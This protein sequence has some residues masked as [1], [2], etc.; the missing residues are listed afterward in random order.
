[1]LILKKLFILF[2][3]YD[4]L[5]QGLLNFGKSIREFK[6]TNK[7]PVLPDA[8]AYPVFFD[9]HLVH[10]SRRIKALINDP[11]ANIRAFYFQ[12]LMLC[13]EIENPNYEFYIAKLQ[14]FIMDPNFLFLFLEEDD[15]TIFNDRQFKRFLL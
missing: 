6:N 10:P 1:V 14:K 2:K 12:Y 5:M 11:N 15:E 8:E 13:Y 4:K 3:A 9:K 7:Q